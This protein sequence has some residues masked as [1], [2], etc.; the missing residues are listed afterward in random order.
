M[1]LGK[2][3]GIMGIRCIKKIAVKAIAILAMAAVT[4]G[5][6]GSYVKPVGVSA[7]AK[8]QTLYDVFRDR[9][10]NPD[11]FMDQEEFRNKILA[12]CK[13]L[14]KVA[15]TSGSQVHELACDGFVS[16]VLRITFGTVHK[17]K[18]CYDYKEKKT[19]MSYEFD[20]REE[21]IVAN[22]YV[23]KYE[24]YGPGGTSVT[25]LYNNYVGKLVDARGSNRKKVE[26]FTNKNWVGYMESIGAQPGDIIMWDNDYNKTY[27][28]HIGIYAGVENGK[29]MMWHASAVKGKVCKQALSEITEEVKYLKLACVVPMTDAPAKVGLCADT[30]SNFRDFS[31]S[32]YK[33]EDCSDFIGRIASNCTLKDQA[34]LEDIAI[35]LNGDKTAYE[36]TVYVRRDM[37]PF[38]FANAELAG[39]DQTVYKLKIKITPGEENKGTLTYTI[40][41]SKDIR[42]YDSKTIDDYDYR[43]GGQVILISDYR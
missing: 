13:L 30:A 26:G 38:K 32:I 20:R 12:N 36:K 15:Y 14:N 25:W 23:D 27:W 33:D 43:S 17:V 37:S 11:T 2:K 41:G 5:I 18:V 35:Y 4:A 16:M 10:G 24:V 21:H 8:Y 19:L 9:S 40:Y 29:A 3:R 28:T 39:A 1:L 34:S 22:S 31:Y 7:A 42:Y 6:A